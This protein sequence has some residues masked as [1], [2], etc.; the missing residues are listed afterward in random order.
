MSFGNKQTAAESFPNAVVSI[1]EALLK[2]VASHRVYPPC[3]SLNFVSNM[4]NEIY[5][6]IVYEIIVLFSLSFKV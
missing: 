4:I 5:E 2:T 6:I 3:L 1:Q